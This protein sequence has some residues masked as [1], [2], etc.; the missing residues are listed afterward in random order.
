M[1]I[2]AQNKEYSVE[3]ERTDSLAC[4]RAT[5]VATCH[6]HVA[7]SRLSN[8]YTTTKSP[9]PEGVGLFVVGEDGFVYIFIPFKGMK[10]EDRLG[11]ALAGG[12]HSRRI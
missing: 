7:K 6:R 3:E 4:G 10:I 9:T 2:C 12:A 11:R 8:P 1:H 5:A